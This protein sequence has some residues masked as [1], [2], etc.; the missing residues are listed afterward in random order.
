MTT[1]IRVENLGK[2]Y[3]IGLVAQKYQTLSEK[4]TTALGAPLR[5]IRRVQAPSRT[6]DTIWALQGYQFRGRAGAGVGQSSGAM[7]PAK[8]RC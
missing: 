5:A 4:V 6:E 2:R 7:E 1:V 8:A 3:R